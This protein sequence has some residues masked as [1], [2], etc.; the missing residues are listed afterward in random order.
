[1][2]KERLFYLDF[3]RALATL[4]IILTHYNAIYLYTVPQMQ[5]K[6]VGTIFIDGVYIGSLGVG[7]FLIISGSALMYVYQDKFD[8]KAFYKKRFLN[9][10]PMFW[11]GYFL[12]FLLQ[13]YEF[14]GILQIPRWKIIYSVLGIDCYVN[15]FGFS[16]FAIVGEWFLGFIIIF[17]LIFP[18]VRSWIKKNPISLFVF[19]LG[20][21][22]IGIAFEIPHMDI[23]LIG[24]L[25]LLVFGMA[26]VMY[27]KRVNAVMVVGAVLWLILNHIISPYLNMIIRSSLMSIAVFLILIYISQNLSW[28]PI[29]NV[30]AVICKYSYAIFIIHHVIINRMVKWFDLYEISRFYSYL[31]FLCCCCVIFL[32]AYLLQKLHDKTMLLF[33]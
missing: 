24:L 33:K 10:Y 28:K 4:L 2:K 22:V 1:M 15:A 11:L 29:R 31:L 26:F 18:L 16:S 21:F 6:A 9:I 8:I 32:A 19:V 30:C 13:F 5:E 20:L 14:R 3:V 23:T 12:M 25:P 17:Y 27:I 7:L